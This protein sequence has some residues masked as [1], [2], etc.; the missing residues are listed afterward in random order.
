M[1]MLN[2]GWV[3]SSAGCGVL[4]DADRHAADSAGT[5]AC[6]DGDVHAGRVTRRHAHLR[7]LHAAGDTPLTS[8]LVCHIV[9]PFCCSL[10]RASLGFL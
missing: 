3:L 4:A 6:S 5:S 2:V 7:Q 8:A 1:Q 9:L 10:S